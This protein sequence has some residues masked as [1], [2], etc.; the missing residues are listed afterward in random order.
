MPTI[1]INSNNYSGITCNIN[2]TGCTGNTDVISGVTLPYDYTTS[3]YE[4]SYSVYF[5]EY[6]RTCLL[7]ITCPSP[8]PSVTPTPS[9]TPSVWTPLNFSGITHYWVSDSLVTTSGGTVQSWEDVLSGVVLTPYS[10]TTE[11]TYNASDSSYNN[12]VTIEF[13]GVSDNLE[14]EVSSGYLSTDDIS[15][16]IV[17]APVKTGVNDYQMIGGESIGQSR[18]IML[19]SSSPGNIDELGVYTFNSGGRQPNGYT[20]NSGDLIW[21]GVSRDNSTNTL[22]QYVNSSTPLTTATNSNDTPS[23]FQ[24]YMGSYSNGTLLYPGKIMEMIFIKGVP[25][26]A[27][28]NNFNTYVTNKY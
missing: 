18:E 1:R 3:S 23:I 26:T 15:I 14:D 13:D 10:G 4:G 20:Y 28:L 19:F 27:E 8:T 6:D 12:Q 21:Q 7:D 5:P 16:F 25:T 9:A 17:H 11:P 24:F 22:H 2:F